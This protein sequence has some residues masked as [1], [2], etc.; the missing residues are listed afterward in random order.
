MKHDCL[1]LNV[2][3]M[4]QLFS[5]NEVKVYDAENSLSWLSVSAPA[6]EALEEGRRSGS[7]AGDF[8]RDKSLLSSDLP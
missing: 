1:R 4:I 2:L 6:L 8:V 7:L 3:E 5:K